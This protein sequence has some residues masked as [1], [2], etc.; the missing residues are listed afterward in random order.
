MRKLGLVVC[1]L[2]SVLWIAP[3]ASADDAYLVGRFTGYST[4]NSLG[5]SAI[6]GTVRLVG[7]YLGEPAT[8]T[9]FCANPR[10]IATLT[11]TL[12]SD[13]TDN[14]VL[15]DQLITQ[16][17]YVVGFFQDQE[18]WANFPEFELTC[19]GTRD[20]FEDKACRAT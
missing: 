17:F 8:G 2:A 11:C 19:L 7:S 18:W 20:R 12:L 13:D 1:A 9:Y 15:P 6:E 14:G 5:D 16:D 3:P 4:A 10:R